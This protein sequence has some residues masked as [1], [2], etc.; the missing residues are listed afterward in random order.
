[1]TA[2]KKQGLTKSQIK[3]K[4]KKIQDA[5]EKSKLEKKFEHFK[6]L[7]QQEI[8]KKL[9][10]VDSPMIVSQAWNDSKPGGTMPFWIGLF[11]PDPTDAERLYLHMW[12]GPGGVDPELS[13]FLSN[14]D[15]RFPRLTQPKFPGLTL[16]SMTDGEPESEL[17]FNLNV[18]SNIEKSTYFANCCLLQGQ[19][20]SFTYK[21][22]DRSTFPICRFVVLDECKIR[23]SKKEDQ[24]EDSSSRCIY[25]PC[26]NLLYR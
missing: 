18:P 4:I 24:N 12:V 20:G 13:I 15:T 11:N 2:K 9:R 8:E 6:A 26:I 21:F 7:T 19:S 10:R 16:A 14:V 25:A 23:E 17:S 22:L 1:M 5:I 3:E